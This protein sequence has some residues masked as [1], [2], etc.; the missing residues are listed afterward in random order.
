MLL[1][2][3]SGALIVKV[4]HGATGEGVWKAGDVL[5][6]IDG[7]KVGNNGT[8]NLHGIRCS[9]AVRSL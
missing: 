3:R 4:G 1:T 6:E 5:L 2:D 7:R 9:L 8:I